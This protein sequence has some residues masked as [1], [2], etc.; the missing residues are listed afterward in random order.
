MGGPGPGGPGMKFR[1]WRIT[2][3]ITQTH[4]IIFYVGRYKMSSLIEKVA[5]LNSYNDD[6]IDEF[7]VN[8]FKT[9]EGRANARAWDLVMKG[10]EFRTLLKAAFDD[11]DKYPESTSWLDFF[12]HNGI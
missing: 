12:N 8:S 9:E 7:I 6:E 4:G 3:Y 5:R 10:P 1:V 11:D 2:L